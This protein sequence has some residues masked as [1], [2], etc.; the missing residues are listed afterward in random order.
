MAVKNLQES[1]LTVPDFPVGGLMMWGVINGGAPIGWLRCD[2]ASYNTSYYPE[3]F[4][5]IGY[6]FGGSGSSFNVPNQISS[7]DGITLVGW[8][9]SGS[10]VGTVIGENN[11]TLT[12]S[13][14]GESST[15]HTHTKVALNTEH[16]HT[17]TSY[18]LGT[19]GGGANGSSA[20][21]RSYINNTALS[22]VTNPST[23]SLQTSLVLTNVSYPATNAVDAHTN[24]QPSVGIE[25]I[26][27][28]YTL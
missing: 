18:L 9:S 13:Q 23:S 26:I 6:S 16:D 14:A 5:R 11:V 25:Y 27:R 3:L 28:A 10:S 7:F 17:L 19:T 15:T 2:G 1:S 20:S 12:S 8:E 22:P 24:I 21:S 4:D